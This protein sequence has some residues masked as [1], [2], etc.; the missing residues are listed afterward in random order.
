MRL[1]QINLAPAA[2]L[3]L[4]FGVCLSS[5]SAG[6]SPRADVGAQEKA[7]REVVRKVFSQEAGRGLEFYDQGNFKEAVKSLKQA[8]QQRHDDATAWH[9]LGLAHEQLG[10]QKDALKAMQQAVLLRLFLLAPHLSG[11]KIKP[12]SELSAE[13]KAERR[14]E[15]AGRYREAL[16]SVEPYLRLGPPAAD[17]WRRQHEALSL[18]VKNEAAPEAEKEVFQGNDEGIVKAKIHYK[19]EPMYT[20]TARSNGTSG[21][22]ILCAVL[23]A[24]GKV[25]QTLALL[26]L[27]D[28]LTEKSIE[29]V[30]RIQFTPATK[31]GRPVSQWVTVEFNFNVY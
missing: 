20:E 31:D 3:S 12:W 17:F 21:S 13:E 10:K 6:G 23:G 29:A 22:V 8:T 4:M 7:E 24:D 26:M 18:H 14:R 2:L 9:F 19:P 28:G 15:I 5:S 25:K 30:R 27:P 1:V 16:A 11:Q